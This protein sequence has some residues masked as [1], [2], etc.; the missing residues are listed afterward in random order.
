MNHCVFCIFLSM[1]PLRNL[2]D[3]HAIHSLRVC[4]TNPKMP[5]LRR[6][7]KL[8]EII[9]LCLHILAVLPQHLTR[10]EWYEAALAFRHEYDKPPLPF[11]IKYIKDVFYH[12]ILAHIPQPNPKKQRYLHAKLLWIIS[13][14]LHKKQFS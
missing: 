8:P 6:F 4:H 12:W 2:I 7:D 5:I 13:I 1:D 11:S 9:S 10:E 14:L 3:H